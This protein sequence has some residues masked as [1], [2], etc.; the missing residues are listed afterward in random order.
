MGPPAVCAAIASRRVV[1]FDYR[2]HHRVVE[3]HAH[4]RGPT[5]KELLRGFQIG[6]T[7]ASGPLGWKLFDMDAV[8]DLRLREERF[9]PRPDFRTD[10]PSMHPVHCCVSTLAGAAHPRGGRRL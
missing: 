1:E 2:G 10:D 4:G 3:P 7:S 9:A 8:F 5:N 6:G